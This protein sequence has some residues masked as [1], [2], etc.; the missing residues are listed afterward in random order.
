M[1]VLRAGMANLAI[2]VVTNDLKGPKASKLKVL[3]R[4]SQQIVEVGHTCAGKG[5]TKI[6]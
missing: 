6:C 4:T 5:G 1:S 3:V 2:P